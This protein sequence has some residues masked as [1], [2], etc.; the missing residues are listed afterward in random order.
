MR[1]MPIAGFPRHLIFYRAEEKEIRILR[2]VHGAR[3]LE[4]LF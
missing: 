2:V 4:S 1:R 3:D